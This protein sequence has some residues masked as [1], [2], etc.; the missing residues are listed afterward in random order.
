MKIAY[1]ILENSRIKRPAVFLSCGTFARE[2]KTDSIIIRLH[3]W[4]ISALFEITEFLRE[5]EEL[6]DNS[7]VRRYNDYTKIT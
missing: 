6:L 1:V 5:Y 3:K 7:W 4:E 2:Y